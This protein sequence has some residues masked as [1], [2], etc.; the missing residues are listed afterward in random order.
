MHT[1]TG[2]GVFQGYGC[3]ISKEMMFSKYCVCGSGG[4]C[5]EK[6]NTII[7]LGSRQ[8]SAASSH[9]LLKPP[10]PVFLTPVFLERN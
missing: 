5:E 6:H 8:S 1:A 9:C 3:L 4:G 10:D 2:F 7:K